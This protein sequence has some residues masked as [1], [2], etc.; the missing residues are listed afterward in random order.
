MLLQARQLA[1]FYSPTLSFR[2]SA[3]TVFGANCIER[4]I[5]SDPGTTFKFY[6]ENYEISVFF[7]DFSDFL[8][9]R[10]FSSA[11]LDHFQVPDSSEIA[12]SS[13]PNTKPTLV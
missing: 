13:R 6:L 10:C 3:Q 7:D 9:N 4:W 2:A 1:K 12:G 8:N 5:S 11:N